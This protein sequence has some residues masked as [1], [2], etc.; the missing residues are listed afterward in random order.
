MPP[1]PGCRTPI[2]ANVDAPAVDE[3]GTA[4]LRIYDPIDSWGGDWGVSAREFADALRQVPNAQQIQLHLNSPGGEVFEAIAILNGLRNHPATVTAVVDGLAASAASFIA[5]GVDRLV[6]GQNSQLMVHDPWGICI[7]PATD[8]RNLADQLD[9]IGDNIASVYQGKAGGALADWRAV[10]LAETWYSAEE[11]VTA[12]LAD[13][14]AGSAGQD[15]QPQ[16]AFDLN[17][18]QYPG[19]A[20]APPPLPIAA[21]VETAADLRQLHARRHRHNARRHGLPLLERTPTV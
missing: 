10:M 21:S 5:A 2:R 20:A 9:H 7:G 6:M 4:T 19:R 8:M 11:A 12:G 16:N 1:T 15:A 3:T 14:V 13:E 18:F 17:T